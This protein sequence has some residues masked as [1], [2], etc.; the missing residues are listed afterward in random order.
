MFHKF[1]NSIASVKM[2]VTNEWIAQSNYACAGF[3]SHI[4]QKYVAC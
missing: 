3:F 4:M 2:S 1:E